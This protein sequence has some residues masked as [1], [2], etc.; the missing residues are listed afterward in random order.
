MPVM[1]STWYTIKAAA[2]PDAVDIAIFDEIG[3]WGVTA[4]SFIT[5]L[6]AKAKDGVKRANL[7]INS[8]GGSVFEGWAIFNALKASG[9]EIHVTVMGIAASMASVIAMAG[10]TIT[11]P[12]NSMMM[13]HNAIS[14]VYG[15]AEDLRAVVEVLD[16][17]D[18]SIVATYVAR[19]GKPEDEVRALMSADTFMTAAEALDLGFATAVI[20]P[21][22]A[23]ASFDI[24]QL[25]EN[26][27]AVFKA[28]APPPKP[29]SLA[30]QIKAAAEAAGLGEYAASWAV[31]DR[32]P[33]MEA[34][35]AAIADA[36]E[37]VALCEMV[38]RPDDAG[39][40]IRARAPIVDVRKALHAALAAADQATHTDGSRPSKDTQP[41]A[42]AGKHEFNPAAV[43]AEVNKRNAAM[44]GRSV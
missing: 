33:T 10:K 16:K 41:E 8:P 34:V 3:Y 21:V 44:S 28:V 12:A 35:N 39:D 1:S 24:A 4:K 13:V 27:R 14:G 9:L 43:W 2:T 11:M 20:D 15:D 19:T 30:A 25:P 32:L 22:E 26:V 37:V 5:D 36:V 42:G 18:N 31:D 17:I 23:R 29:V 40:H 7:S 38:G 6:K